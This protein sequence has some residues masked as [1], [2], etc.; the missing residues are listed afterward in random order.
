MTSGGESGLR[1]TG[2]EKEDRQTT[3]FGNNHN[4]SDCLLV[5]VVIYAIVVIIMKLRRVITF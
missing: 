3:G 4:V 2:N 1:D 5:T